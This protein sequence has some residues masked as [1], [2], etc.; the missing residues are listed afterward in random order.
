M[1]LVLVRRQVAQPAPTVTSVTPSTGGTVGNTAITD[2]A[3]TGF[4]SGATVTFGGAAA[5]SVVF[6][7]SIKLTCTTPAH[8]AG[9]VS[10][11]VTNPDAQTASLVGGFTY[12]DGGN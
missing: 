2:L 10:I 3:G 12:S 11:A 8:A 6:V 5:T 9:T 4:Q 7:S 1:G